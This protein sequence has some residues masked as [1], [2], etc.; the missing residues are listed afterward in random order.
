M[1]EAENKTVGEILDRLKDSM[2]FNLSLANTELFHSNFL[3][4]LWEHGGAYADALNAYFFEVKS[5]D[6]QDKVVEVRRE[7]K[8]LDL[9]VLVKAKETDKDQDAERILV[10]ENKVKS[11][12]Q[13]AQLEGYRE[14]I[15]KAFG[16]P[17]GRWIKCVL[18][19]PFNVGW[20]DWP[21]NWENATHM[22]IIECVRTAKEE[23][24]QNPDPYLE[25]AV[26]DFCDSGDDL[27]RLLE[28]YTVKMEDETP[29][30]LPES[31]L[32]S[33]TRYRMAA[34]IQKYRFAGLL[35]LVKDAWRKQQQ[36]N[37][38][39][40]TEDWQWGT[41]FHQET[42]LCEI[43]MFLKTPWTKDTKKKIP[44]VIL[45]L[46]GNRFSIG[47]EH[48]P[49]SSKTSARRTIKTLRDDAILMPEDWCHYPKYLECDA[50]LYRCKG[51]RPKKNI[52]VNQYNEFYY[53]YR[54]LSPNATAPEIVD[55]FM[56]HWRHIVERHKEIPAYFKL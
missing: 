36:G 22:E 28:H 20:A 2:L 37:G 52:E 44:S 50:L 8:H 15:Q 42:A 51:S 17:E 18:L 34:L 5:G 39:M 26:L 14:T 55:L 31:E 33:L 40:R 45:Q 16:E 29:F 43:K 49:E 24:P 10:I 47:V 1:C 35:R 13:R 30:L 27:C 4:W 38:P 56:I 9:V 53:D 12:P 46:H 25:H 11:M 21:E 48:I 3:A 6:L 54:L 41:N 7:F 23:T 19:T 32:A